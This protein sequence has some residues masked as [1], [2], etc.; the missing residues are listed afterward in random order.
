M[1]SSERIFSTPL[2]RRLAKQGNLDLKGLKGT[3]PRGRIVKADIEAALKGGGSKMASAPQG[4][5][6]APA[7]SIASGAGPQLIP[8]SMMRKVIAKR[9]TESKQTVPHFYLTVDC[10]IDSLLDMRRKLNER[11][12]EEGV[13]I[14]VNDIVIKAAAAALMKVPNANVS[15]TEQGLLQYSTVDISVAVAIPGGLITPVLRSIEQKGLKQISQEMGALAE[16]A[17]AGKLQPEEYQGGSFSISNLG[18]YGIK[19]FGAIINPP[20][21]AILAV[22]AGEQRPIV[23]NGELAIAN[24]MTCTLSVDHRAIDGAVGAEFV[25]A[26]KAFIEEPYLMVA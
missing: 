5:S 8:H 18:M 3:G 7:A 21:G 16:R 6:I 12:K 20:Q 13:K 17:R 22:G 14:S 11:F 10:E 15:W 25:K 9:L 26:F 1:A 24:I 19:E 23:K 2:A 4:F